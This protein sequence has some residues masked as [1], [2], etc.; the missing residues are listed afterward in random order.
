MRP[1]LSALLLIAAVSLSA[2]STGRARFPSTASNL[3]LSRVVL[4][5]NGVG[6]FERQGEVDG[7]VLRLRVRK[8]QVNDL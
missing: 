2:C 3:E 4:Y 7:D 6:Y 1:A 5:R 8:E